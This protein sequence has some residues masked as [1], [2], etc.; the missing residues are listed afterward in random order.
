MLAI[1]AEPSE[2]CERLMSSIRTYSVGRTRSWMMILLCECRFDARCDEGQPIVIHGNRGLKNR[3]ETSYNHL[4]TFF[5][6]INAS[7]SV[8]ASIP[9]VVSTSS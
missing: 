6:K 8:P 4:Y 3:R 1:R 5:S 2:H 9:A 7:I